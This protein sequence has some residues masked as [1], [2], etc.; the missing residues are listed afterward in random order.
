MTEETLQRIKE[1]V[2]NL[3]EKPGVY[4]MKDKNG[5]II[6]VGKA[7]ILKNRVSQYF[8]SLSSHTPKVLR[9]VS[10]VYDFDYIITGSEME[11]LVLECSEIKHYKPYYNILLKDDKNYPYLKVDLESEYPE[12]TITRTRKNDKARYFGPYT[13]KASEIMNIIRHTFKLPSC[14]RKFPRDIGKERPCLNFSINNCI[15]LCTGNISKEE[16]RDIIKNVISFLEGNYD[17]VLNDIKEQM[18]IAADNELFEKAAKLRD[19]MFAVKRLSESQK[20]VAA[21]NVNRDVIGYAENEYLSMATLFV[22]RNGRIIS[23][24]NYPLDRADFENRGEGLAGFLKQ[25]YSQRADIPK[26]LLLPFESEDMD[27]L[28]DFL[29]DRAGKKINIKVPQ[30]GELKKLVGMVSENAEEAVRLSLKKEEKAAKSIVDLQ[31]ALNLKAPPKRIEAIDISNIKGKENVAAIILFVNGEKD[32]SGYKRFKIKSFEGQDDYESMREVVWRRLKR[33]EEKYK[34]FEVLPDLFLVDGGKG[35]VSAVKSIF[36]EFNIDIPVFGMVK[37]EK[38]R[39]RGLVNEIGDVE[40]KITSPAFSLISK[41]QEEVHRFAIGYHKKLRS[42][43]TIKS[44]LN[45]IPGLGKVR[46]KNLYKVFGSIDNIKNASFE[47]LC[48]VPGMNKS[49][50]SEVLRY[51]GN[52]DTI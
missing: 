41:I 3:P 14:S 44:E 31:N 16:Y 51:F 25:I 45:N 38:H 52:A 36:S 28:Q 1:K 9:M 49:A 17:E 46:V 34:G 13:G 35:Q 20:V 18:L 39:T 50:A 8:N 30:R 21:P 19:R 10:Q 23:K 2:K 22:I 48:K 32:K 26:E 37:D 7:K 40:L 4:Y 11:A 5:H 42:K 33:Y 6:Y 12:V 24:V 29:S 43:N 47:E 15:G 27:L